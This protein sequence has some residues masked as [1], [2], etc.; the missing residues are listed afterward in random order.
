VVPLCRYRAGEGESLRDIAV[1]YHTNWKS[2]FLL[3]P[4]L[5]HP[6]ALEPG[7]VIQVGS[8]YQ[9]GDDDS[10][11]ELSARVRVPW[12]SL[13]DNNA[14]LVYRLWSDHIFLET[15]RTGQAPSQPIGVL[16]P[17]EGVYDIRFRDLD[18]RQNYSERE[19]CLVAQFNTNCF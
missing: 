8:L 16:D 3:N 4:Q 10:L 18:M 9:L 1:R 15:A 13:V 14:A 2:L 17:G 19:V 7:T 12:T 5:Q 6:L 11:E